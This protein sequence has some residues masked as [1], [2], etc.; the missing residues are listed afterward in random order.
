MLENSQF[1]HGRT[2]PL[3]M[4]FI[5]EPLV[6]FLVLGA[7][8]FG[9][10]AWRGAAVVPVTR[11]DQIIITSGLIDNLRTS[12]ERMNGHAPDAKELDQA[13]EAYVR[14]E[15]L[16]REARALGFDRDDSIVRQ[17][18]AQRMEFIAT[19]QVETHTPSDEELK[20]FFQKNLNLFKQTDGTVPEFTDVKD[21]VRLA[22]F[23][24]QR[25]AAS[26]AAY[27]KMRANYTVIRQDQADAKKK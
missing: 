2:E 17:R 19:A 26:D 22:W 27:E 23:D 16:N 24:A 14:E 8:L 21:D 9:L 10:F 5:R 12:F 7:A 3:N 4:K 15:V 13:V 20:S 18:L 11:T 25:Q 1:V 6:H